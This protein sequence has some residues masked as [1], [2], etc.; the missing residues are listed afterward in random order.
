MQNE[1]VVPPLMF[2]DYIEAHMYPGHVGV[3]LTNYAQLGAQE[4]VIDWSFQELCIGFPQ[5]LQGAKPSLATMSVFPLSYEY[6]WHYK[7]G[8]GPSQIICK[9]VKDDQLSIQLHICRDMQG[10]FAQCY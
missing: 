4:F 8:T 3:C 10:G 6:K 9:P 2:S 1:V 7:P 5:H